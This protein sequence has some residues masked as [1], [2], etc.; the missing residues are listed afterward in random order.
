MIDLTQKIEPA[1]EP[2]E[3]LKLEPVVSSAL[4]KE[5]QDPIVNDNKARGDDESKSEEARVEDESS[6]EEK[7]GEPTEIRTFKSSLNYYEFNHRRWCIYRFQEKSQTVVIFPG[8]R[9][10]CISVSLVGGRGDLPDAIS[11]PGSCLTRMIKKNGKS[12]HELSLIVSFTSESLS[13]VFACRGFNLPLA[14][15]LPER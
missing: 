1:I 8:T 9:F 14:S 5:V 7:E 4:K 6:T 12:S 13:D 2:V 11:H 15:F 3:G 10:D